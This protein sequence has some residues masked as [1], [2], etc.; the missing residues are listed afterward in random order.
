MSKGRVAQL[1]L[2]TTMKDEAIFTLGQSSAE[3]GFILNNTEGKL[4]GILTQ[5]R[6]W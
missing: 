3:N 1:E 5:P 6:S 4:A 2:V